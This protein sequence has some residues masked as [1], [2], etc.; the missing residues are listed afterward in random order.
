MVLP[1]KSTGSALPMLVNSVALKPA[2]T[3]LEVGSPVPLFDGRLAPPASA[4]RHTYDV[5]RDG[6]QFYLLARDENEK[7]IPVTL[8]LD[9]EAGLKK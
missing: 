5:T 6:R 4:A 8:L 3:G 9:W 1:L 7:T 2:G